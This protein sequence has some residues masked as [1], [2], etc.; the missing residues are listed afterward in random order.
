MDH[1]HHVPF[2]L[3]VV[4]A[5][6][7]GTYVADA[8][9]GARPDARIALFERT[10]RIGGR[11]RSVHVPGVEHPIELGGMRFQSDH[12]HVLR[13]VAD[14]GI[15]TR[16]F[17]MAQPE[18]RLVLRG[19]VARADDAAT[20]GAGYDLAADERG[21]T[22]G[23]VLML[24]F[25]RLV[26]NTLELDEAGWRAL[27]PVARHQDRLLA[28]WPIGEALASVLSP[29]GHRYV[30][31]A[32]GYDSGIRGQNAADAVPYFTG[33]GDP[34]ATSRTPVDGMDAMP[35]AL[36][37]RIERRGGEIHLNHE[38][39]AV[40]PSQGDQI[41]QLRFAN[42]S[43]TQARQ[44]VLALTKPALASI[45]SRSPFL[46]ESRVQSMIESVEAWMGGK[47]Y[48]WYERAWWRDSDFTGHRA[49]TDL[50]PRKLFYFDD[51]PNGP[52]V[53]LG[54]YTDGND[55]DPWLA[56]SD[57]A[58]DG[59]PAPNAMVDA[60]TGYLAAIHPGAIVPAPLGSAFMHWG[61]DPHETAWHYWC[62][63]AR[64]WE[65][66]PGM[67]KPDPDH[68][69]YTCGEAY[70]TSQAWVEGALESASLVVDRLV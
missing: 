48:L 5:G 70:S 57:G 40:E 41:L 28:D 50:P 55:L 38:L 42:G 3:A 9:F 13:V 69:L 39:I 4:G 36:A 10:D 1:E 45:A 44:V 37:A 23:A 19:H 51:D 63:R 56:L 58:S 16:P 25:Q 54:S 7:A 68:E 60:L 12:R 33:T 11:L 43:T 20:A 18:D 14:L 49:T 8:V 2:D 65:V 52:A 24:A 34:H 32:F 53:L 26:P 22:P 59:E 29:A 21:L 47:F 15:G 62:A 31:D 67:V 66:I 46:A 30:T 61:A 17:D 27:K 6:I 35:R 64:S